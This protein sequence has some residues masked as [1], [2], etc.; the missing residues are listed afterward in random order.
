MIYFLSDIIILFCCGAWQ[1]RTYNPYI[2][3][4]LAT[5]LPSKS[6]EIT[7]LPSKK[8]NFHETLRISVQCSLICWS[9]IQ[10]CA[11]EM[12]KIAVNHKEDRC[13][14]SEQPLKKGCV[15]S[16]GCSVTRFSDFPTAMLLSKIATYG[17]LT[18]EPSKKTKGGNAVWALVCQRLYG[19]GWFWNIPVNSAG[20]RG[21]FSFSGSNMVRILWL[22]PSPSVWPCQISSS[23][24]PSHLTWIFP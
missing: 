20:G 21:H 6:L 13:T 22:L 10:S 7:L 24:N 14:R 5:L 19:V 15:R 18:F 16:C 9:V 12:N 3:I 4:I 23:M 8:S 2:L 1:H 17:S 11:V